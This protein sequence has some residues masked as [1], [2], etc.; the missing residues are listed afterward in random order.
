[1]RA[2][3]GNYCTF[4]HGHEGYCC[5]RNYCTSSYL[6]V[7]QATGSLLSWVAGT[8]R[9]VLM[10]AFAVHFAPLLTFAGEI[11]AAEVF[12]GPFVSD[13]GVFT[14]DNNKVA[15]QYLRTF[16]KNSS[17]KCEMVVFSQDG[18]SCSEFSSIYQL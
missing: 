3:Y 18:R 15:M 10:R 5:S 13:D 2:L 6:K 8:A 1:M 17:K 7:C 12:C 16:L 11:D 4:P 9:I 14:P